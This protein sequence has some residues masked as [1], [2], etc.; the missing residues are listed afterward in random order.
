MGTLINLS[1]KRRIN[2]HT[3]QENTIK[4]KKKNYFT[5]K[6]WSLRKSIGEFKILV[7]LIQHLKL[8]TKKKGGK[9]TSKTYRYWSVI[10]KNDQKLTNLWRSV[11]PTDRLRS[12]FFDRF[13]RSI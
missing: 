8:T 2:K 5:Y 9:P 4:V 6:R 3:F 1:L 11:G 7:L 13:G 10:G 12:V